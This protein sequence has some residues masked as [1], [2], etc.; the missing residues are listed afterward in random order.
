MRVPALACALCLAALPAIAAPNLLSP[1][2]RLPPS[3]GA[4]RVALTLDA[5]DGQ[6][7]LRILD[8]L[9][10][11]HVPATI[12]ASGLWIAR[13][14][15]AMAVLLAHPDLFEV[16][17]HGDR[18]RPAVTV[19]LRIWGLRAA[20]SSQAVAAE[21]TGGAQDLLR[22]GAPA[23]RWY[24]GAGAEYDAGA[25]AEIASLGY[26]LAGFSL[27]ADQGASLPARAVRARIDAAT[28]GAV[29]IAHLNQPRRPAGQGVAQGIADLLAQG[30]RFVRLRDV[31]PDPA[32]TGPSPTGPH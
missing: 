29:L 1:A 11:D 19:P 12:F 9:L 18:H 22:A 5:C 31:W 27:N 4:P 23:P 25:E 15:V 2:L 16:E 28:D 6:V 10:A 24:R 30:V 32:P 3:P 26:R 13:N 8:L 20:G 21:I 14:P 7:D 17:D